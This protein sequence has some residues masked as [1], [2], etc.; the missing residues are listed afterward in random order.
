MAKTHQHVSRAS[1]AVNKQAHTGRQSA[2]DEV[3]E[4]ARW[5]S[6]VEHNV[7]IMNGSHDDAY[8]TKFASVT[9]QQTDTTEPTS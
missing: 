7:D 6:N 2:L 4:Q 5:L 8:G 9:L 3:E 1:A